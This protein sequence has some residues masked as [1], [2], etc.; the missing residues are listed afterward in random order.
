MSTSWSVK[1]FIEKMNPEKYLGSCNGNTSYVLEV[2]RCAMVNVADVSIR[3][4][5]NEANYSTPGAAP[6]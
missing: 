5:F 4:P 2:R 3:R 1:K 6:S